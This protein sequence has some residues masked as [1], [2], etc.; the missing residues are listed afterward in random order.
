MNSIT[1]E[2]IVDKCL[3]GSDQIVVR[4]NHDSKMSYIKLVV[5]I[6]TTLVAIGRTMS[7]HFEKIGE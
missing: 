5:D 1:Y 6:P 3:D 2:V 7:R 4:N